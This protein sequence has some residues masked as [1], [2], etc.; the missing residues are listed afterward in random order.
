[1]MM[2]RK[3]RERREAKMWSEQGRVPSIFYYSCAISNELSVGHSHDSQGGIYGRIVNA[4]P[5]K[6][7]E[8]INMTA[9]PSLTQGRQGYPPFPF[10]YS[11]PCHSYTIKAQQSKQG[12][13]MMKISR[14]IY[15]CVYIYTDEIYRTYQVQSK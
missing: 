1:M 12:E 13:A 8:R 14:D 3:R 9:C 15:M 5:I 2:R 6:K 10:S 4:N 7:R 11:L